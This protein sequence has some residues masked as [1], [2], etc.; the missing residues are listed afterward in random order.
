MSLA[1]GVRLGPYEVH[2]LLGSGGMGEVYRAKDTK[3]NRDVALKVLPAALTLDPDR[4]A[5]FTREAHVL[6]SLNHPNIGAIYGFE[7]STSTG[8]RPA[9]VLE[10]VEGPTL[11]DRIAQGRL[12]SDEAFPIA[13]QIADAL[14]AAHERGIVHRDLKPANIKLRPDGTVK[15][16]D[17]GLARLS[18]F[19]VNVSGPAAGPSLSP[20]ITSPAV[21]GAGVILG[22][23]A[24][25]SPEQAKGKIADKRSD[26]WAFG[27]VL[28]EMLT[29]ARAFGGEDVSDTLANVLKSEPDWQ[30]LPGTTPQAT[31]RLLRRSLAKDLNRRLS[32][33]ADAR[34]EIEESLAGA[35]DERP[36]PTGFARRERIV[37][38]SIVG[39]L[40]LVAGA[41]V[42][43]ALRPAAAARE[44]RL[45]MTTPPTMQPEAL[46]ISPDGQ[47]I[48]FSAGVDGRSQLWIRS[49]NAAAARPLAQTDGAT[50]PFWSPD[51]RSLG[52][53]ADGKLKRIDVDDGA[54]RTLADAR[55]PEGGTWN[56]DGVILFSAGLSDPIL[57]INASGGAPIAATQLDQ[58]SR[59]GHTRPRF[60]PDGHHFLFNVRGPRRD[61]RGIFSAVLDRPDT[62]RLLDADFITPAYTSGH[63]L[64]LRL[65]TLFAQPFDAAS[66]ALSGD[67][68]TLAEGVTAF[69]AAAP[70]NSAAGPIVYRSG[71]S[72]RAQR[73]LVWFD[74]SGKEISRLGD[75][76]LANTGV[77]SMSPDGRQVALSRV[78]EEGRNSDIWLLDTA[79][80]V[81]T[82]FTSS[83]SISNFPLWSPDGKRIVFQSGSKGVLDLYEKATSGTA[84]EELLLASPEYKVPSD[85]SVDGRFLLYRS[86][87]EKMGFDI[88][89]LPMDGDRKPFPV[90]RTQFS[91]R[92][93]QFSP[94]GKWIAF[95]SDESGRDEIYVQPFP[96]PG[97]KV[98]IS[99]NGGIQVRWRQDGRELFYIAADDQLMAVP[100]KV[101]SDRQSIEPGAPS[102]LFPARVGRIAV[103]A[104]VDLPRQQYIVSSD[105]Q[106]FL[107]NTLVNDTNTDPITVILNWD[108]AGGR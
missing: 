26:V 70:A 46:A 31:R 76:Y 63:L 37:W 35:H 97:R 65:G 36:I 102:A 44:M 9:L 105:G 61:E 66:G 29:G 41:A 83:S 40:T 22:T 56:Q 67:R 101:S 106:R 27:C 88:W 32:D 69:D 15:V 16:L 30:M 84:P 3:L 21:T 10:L 13:K 19:D 11:A 74:R 86:Q 99:T 75:V 87:T 1:P 73:Q 23:A 89:A 2:S 18:A 91:E 49:L 78:V 8:S 4:L 62:N 68:V 52:F 85:W 72:G 57:R 39:L 80:G 60:L 92:D 103:G 47:R 81:S 34:L 77:P 95:Q 6:A 96:G 55:V 48:V 104:V 38:A 100:I 50:H 98:L 71:R 42:G 7:E 54:V 51:S 58:S 33:I 12:S 93:G 108:S 28:Y 5:R 90:V 79:R 20:T 82:R 59:Q 43:W 14:E 53:F 25:M 107:M 64:F 45:E 94:D 24:Y 17:F